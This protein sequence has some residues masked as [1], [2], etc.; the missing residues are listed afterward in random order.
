MTQ[1]L[2]ERG[3]ALKGFRTREV[4]EMAKYQ[5]LYWKEIPA[6]VKVF[7]GAKAISRQ[8]PPRYQVEIDRVA[9]EQGLAGSD[10]Y[11][12]QW[13]WSA[14]LERAGSAQEVLESVTQELLAEWDPKIGGNNDS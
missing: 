8:L 10:D 1:T 3:L 2:R 9:M 6:Q 4:V 14:K 5:I 12:N 13:H 11:L 7:D